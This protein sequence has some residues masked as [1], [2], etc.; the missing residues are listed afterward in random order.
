MAFF[1]TCRT[2]KAVKVDSTLEAIKYQAQKKLYNSSNKDYRS[3]LTDIIELCDSCESHESLTETLK[4]RAISYSNMI[5]NC[6]QQAM[7]NTESSAKRW[8]EAINDVLL[9][10]KRIAGR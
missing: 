8:L 6:N 2:I 9:I 10:E 7:S 1:K 5:R 3:E 4:K